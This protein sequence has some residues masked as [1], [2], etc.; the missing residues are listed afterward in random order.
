MTGNEY[1]KLAMRTA[2]LKVRH[3]NMLRN[4]AYG[5]N[6]EAGE[7]IDELKKYEF[8]GHSLDSGSLANELGDVLWYV[9][10][11]C[12]ALNISLE[13][14]MQLNICKLKKRYPNGF[15]EEASVHREEY[16]QIEISGAV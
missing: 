15:S 2:N 10:L 6:G 4:A 12:E 14:V 13:T 3:Y 16:D 5:L 9:A 1:Q 8:Q 11:A 7:F